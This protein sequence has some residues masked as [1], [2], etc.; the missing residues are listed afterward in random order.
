MR[1]PASIRF[2]I[3]QCAVAILVFCAPLSHSQTVY[4][5]VKDG[6]VSY[7][8]KPPAGNGDCVREEIK[9]YEPK[10]EEVARQLEDMR[11]WKEREIEEQNAINQERELRAQEIA[12]EAALIQA[13]AAEEEQRRQ[14]EFPPPVIGYP[15]T[16]PYWWGIGSGQIYLQP[17]FSGNPRPHPFHD[18]SMK[19]GP[20]AFKPQF[21]PPG[22]EHHRPP[23]AMPPP[24][25]GQPRPP[26]GMPPP[27]PPPPAAG[28]PYRPSPPAGALRLH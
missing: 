21:P 4:K 5:C 9:V 28:S 24:G 22:A 6:K 1:N 2:G 23:G 10:P 16:E 25:S 18:E 13:R 26:A 14:R 3:F 19:H 7:S 27:H 12:A 17:W 8:S 15:L 20:P 11:R